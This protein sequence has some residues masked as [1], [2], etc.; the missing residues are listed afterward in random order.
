VSGTPYAR[1]LGL[2]G[3]VAVLALVIVA[4]LHKSGNV[5]GIAPGRMLA[6]FAVP[7]ALSSLEGDANVA[8]RAHQGTAGGV[9]ACSVRGP[10]VLNVCQL[11][12]RGPVVLALFVDEGSCA[13]ILRQMQ[14]LVGSFPSVRFAAV[15]IEGERSKLR[16][17][18][19]AQGITLPVGIDKD[20]VLASLYK[21]FSCPQ[22]D[23]AYPGGVVQSKALLKQP[24][25]AA[26]RARVS[27]L[28]AAARARGWRASST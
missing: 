16:R 10:Q 15:A 21:V 5:A 6:P 20:G 11:Y 27:A 22:L 2:L 3:L 23:F 12:E 7:L 4:V 14:A 18:L 1:Y 26:L 25:Q 28:L 19:R 13:S 8:T 24:S 9:P 17:T